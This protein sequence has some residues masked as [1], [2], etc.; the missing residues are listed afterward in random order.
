MRTS[1]SGLIV[2]VQ[3][4]VLW[5][6]FVHRMAKMPCSEGRL[7]F[8]VLNCAGVR[9]GA[10][11]QAT[12]VPVS[13][14]E[15][16]PRESHPPHAYTGKLRAFRAPHTPKLSRHQSPAVDTQSETQIHWAQTGKSSW[17]SVVLARDRA[18]L[19]GKRWPTTEKLHLSLK[20]SP[21]CVRV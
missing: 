8:R 13:P 4:R 18:G 21:K 17:N 15:G 6:T 5:H 19:W 3:N 14:R 10:K 1:N 7:W 2:L 11:V 12:E 20:T 9:A 16:A